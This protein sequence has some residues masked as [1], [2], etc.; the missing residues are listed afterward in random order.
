MGKISSH[1]VLDMKEMSE[2]NLVMISI[3]DKGSGYITSLKFK[4]P[5]KQSSYL[6]DKESLNVSR[7]FNGYCVADKY[8]Q[9]LV[10]LECRVYN[11]AV[12]RKGL[13][14]FAASH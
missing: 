7:Q 10:P 6:V 5:I 9:R 13:G 1:P 12:K 14:C 2:N 8:T 4:P 11:L 3:N